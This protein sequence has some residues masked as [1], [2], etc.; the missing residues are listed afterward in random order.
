MADLVYAI[1]DVSKNDKNCIEFCSSCLHIK[2]FTH[3]DILKHYSYPSIKIIQSL[4][5]A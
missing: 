4:I 2:S 3:G 5:V 1:K